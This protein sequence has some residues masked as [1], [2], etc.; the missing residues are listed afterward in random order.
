[1]ALPV[2]STCMYLRSSILGPNCTPQL[3]PRRDDLSYCVYVNFPTTEYIQ[4]DLKGL[5]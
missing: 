3:E 2:T 4:C 5:P 1:M